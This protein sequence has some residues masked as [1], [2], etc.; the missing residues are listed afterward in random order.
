M[1]F[2]FAMFHIRSDSR[3]CQVENL[4]EK[5]KEY[6]RLL[7]AVP[8]GKTF[9]ASLEVDMAADGGDLVTDFVNNIHTNVMV[10]EKARAVLEAEGVRDPDVEYLPFFLKNKKGRRLKEQFF[11]ANVLRTVPCFDWKRSEYKTLR[12]RPKEISRTSLRKLHIL[13]D[14]VPSDLRFFRM[15]EFTDPTLIRSDLL[16]R[17]RAEGCTGMSVIPLGDK[18]R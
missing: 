6:F 18:I 7:E 15:A 17:L 12:N 14:R 2:S 5:Y 11:I 13:E 1:A 8:M 4:D 10:S 16:E 9:P 3:F